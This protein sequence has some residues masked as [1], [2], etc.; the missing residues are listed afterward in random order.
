MKQVNEKPRST[1]VPKKTLKQQ[2]IEDF[3][4]M[5]SE[6][7]MR[8]KA[9][10]PA[11]FAE[12]S[13]LKAE[14]EKLEERLAI[15]QKELVWGPSWLWVCIQGDFYLKFNEEEV[16]IIDEVGLKYYDAY[17]KQYKVGD[18]VQSSTKEL[19]RLIQEAGVDIRQRE[20]CILDYCLK[21]EDHS[22][23]T[24]KTILEPIDYLKNAQGEL[25]Y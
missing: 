3:E 18:D 23:R 15:L 10:S 8:V 19:F 17:A 12:F 13:K 11:L 21:G 4:A 25:S 6:E 14:K 20:D 22:A 24:L 16:R 9:E 1:R 7:A 2:R 5:L